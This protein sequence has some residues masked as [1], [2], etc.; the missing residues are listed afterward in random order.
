[1]HRIIRTKAYE[2]KHGPHFD[3]EH[4]RKAVSK[5]ENEDGSRGQHWSVEETSALANQYG[6]RFDSKFNKYDW[7]VALN[8]VYSDYYKVI[9][10]MTGSNNSKYFVEL[11][12]AWLSDKDIDE[13]KMWYYYIY[14]MCDKLRDAEEEYFDRNYSKYEDEDDDDDEPLPPQQFPMPNQNRKKL[15]DI[16]ISCGGEQKKLTVEEG[17]SLINDTQLG[18][19]VATDKQHI[20]N[21]VKSSYNEYKAKK[22]AVARYDE[23]MTKCEAILKQLDYTEKEPEKE[24][25]RIQ[26]LQDQVRELKDLIKQASNMVPPQMKQMLPQNMQKAMNEAS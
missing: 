11:A 19:T 20:V 15:V 25:P 17:K 8:M 18:L 2:A 24:D 10:N 5:M 14:V 21:M 9:V 13:G 7:Y 23:E 1:M 26:E 12:K 3:E 4:A 22:E 6:I 16:V